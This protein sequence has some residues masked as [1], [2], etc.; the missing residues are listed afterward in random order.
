VNLTP[1]SVKKD[2]TGEQFRLYKLIWCRFLACQ[3]A[4]AV[5]DSV[6]IDVTSAGY[7]FRANHASLK[8][9][10][11]TAVYE[12]GRDDET[13]EKQ[14][15]LPDLKEGEG[16][17]LNGMTPE[18][19]FTKP[20]A[21]FTEAT[22]I[23]A[24]EEKG[25]GRPSTYAP[26]ISTIMDREYVVKEGKYLRTTSL[27]QVVTT[28]MKERFTDI[29]DPAFTANME[30]QLDAVEEGEEDWKAILAN[31]Y[32]GFQA[33]LQQAE[34]D[35]DGERIKIPDEI[36]DEVCDLCGKQLVVKSGRFGRFLACPGF[37]ECTFTKPL[38]VEMPGRCPKCGGRI[39]KKTSRKGYTYY[40][41]EHNTDKNGKYCDFMT[42][43]VP[44]KEDCPLCGRTMFKKSGRG[45]KK[46]FCSNEDCT[47]FVPEDKR[48]GYPRK[49]DGEKKAEGEEA[50]QKP[51]A[52]KK[53]AAAKASPKKE[54]A[55]STKKAAST[56]RKT[57]ASAGKAASAK[58]KAAASA[59]K[60]ASAK[61]KAAASAGKATSAKKKAAASTGKT[62]SKKKAAAE[63][64]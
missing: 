42:W 22:L 60:V 48:G 58:K 1:E 9:S 43:D 52:V 46:P 10:G 14:S 62:A 21:R 5:Y 2:L 37:P 26:I 40:G 36:S 53:T 29:V 47:A 23:R 57:A 19:H 61:K 8:F 20:P 45:F 24:L 35:L 50:A 64:K 7:V 51:A 30:R 11:F 39:L 13:A 31:F 6:T 32:G 33:K 54:T 4:S 38:V 63:K 44:V 27:G 18:Q 3:M 41:C 28:L 12:E 55:A 16:L 59:G 17:N 56:K 15:P 25:I 49:A 34:A